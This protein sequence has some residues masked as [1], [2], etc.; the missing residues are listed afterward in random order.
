MTPRIVHVLLALASAGCAAKQ[1]I[2]LDCIPEEV[3]V[4]V[5]G[6][7]LEERPDALELSAGEPHKLYFKREGHESQLV[8]LDSHID[9]EGKPQLSP[10][11][12]CVKLVPVGVG[13]ELTIE[14]DEDA[15]SDD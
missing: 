10:A 15:A 8:V 6:R 14:A 11:D 3:L 9:A 2:P 7:L 4:Y 13:R 5:D 12:V 1:T